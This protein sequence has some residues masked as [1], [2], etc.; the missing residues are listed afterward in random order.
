LLREAL[1]CG[2]KKKKMMVDM[3][4]MS[5]L[6]Y[7]HDTV[8]M[9]LYIGIRTARYGSYTAEPPIERGADERKRAFYYVQLRAALK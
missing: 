9:P 4:P 8:L 6:S 1:G 3:E 7:R 5:D 2:K